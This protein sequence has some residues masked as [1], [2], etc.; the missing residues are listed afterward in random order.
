MKFDYVVLAAFLA[1]GIPGIAK[2][3]GANVPKG[4]SIDLGTVS[5]NAY[6][7]PEPSGFHVVA[8][9]APNDS[10]G[11]PVRIEAILSDGQGI[12]VS[13]PGQVGRAGRVVDIRRDGDRIVVG[14]RRQ[15]EL[16]R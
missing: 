2:A 8:T 10:E 12:K 1:I 16:Q 4:Q 9:L 11:T 6:Y 7:L 3:E 13:T 15:A 5:G 14:E